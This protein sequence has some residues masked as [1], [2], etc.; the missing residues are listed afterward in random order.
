[1]LNNIFQLG[2]VKIGR[3]LNNIFHWGTSKLDVYNHVG[4]CCITSFNWDMK[5]RYDPKFI[6]N[7]N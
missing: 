2:Y 7:E 5:N 4:G 3:V 6:S 1:M